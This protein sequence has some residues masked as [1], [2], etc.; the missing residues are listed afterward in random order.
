MD[1]WGL[2]KTPTHNGFKYF[3]TIVDDFS[4]ETWTFLLS[5]KANV[6]TILKHFLAMIERQF[7]TTV[8]ILRSDNALELGSSKETSLFLAEKGII[9]QTSC[10]SSPQ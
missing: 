8:K 10:T 6:F 9:H 1:T 3:L 2:Y 5:T 4:R 7:Q